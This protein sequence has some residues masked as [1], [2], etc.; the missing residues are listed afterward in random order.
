MKSSS[1]LQGA[2]FCRRRVGPYIHTPK[3]NS[4]ALDTKWNSRGRS[5]ADATFLNLFFFLFSF[6]FPFPNPAAAVAGS[7]R[8]QANTNL[9]HLGVRTTARSEY[10]THPIDTKSI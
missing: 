1:S 3:R 7:P 9:A 8:P 10:R 2:G 6:F 5:I 4:P